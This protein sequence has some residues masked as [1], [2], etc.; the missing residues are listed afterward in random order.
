MSDLLNVP[1]IFGTDVFNNATMQQRLS[2]DTY[3]AYRQCLT[4]GSPLELSIA[5]EIAEAMKLWA[6]E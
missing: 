6:I 3:Q 2:A 1:E 4:S 5:N